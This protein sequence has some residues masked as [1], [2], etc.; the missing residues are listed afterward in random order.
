MLICVAN[1]EI[2]NY[3][4]YRVWLLNDESSGGGGAANEKQLFPILDVLAKQTTM[5]NIKLTSNIY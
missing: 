5:K 3:I 1:A 2:S 4:P